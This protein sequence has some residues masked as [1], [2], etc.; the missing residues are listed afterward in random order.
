MMCGLWGCKGKLNISPELL[1]RFVDVRP[2]GYT[3]DADF[4]NTY[5]HPLIRSS[6]LVFSFKPDGVL[7]DTTE[8]IKMI[9]YPL[10]NQ[11]FC[12]NV[13]LYGNG[14]PFHE[15]VQV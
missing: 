12:G 15:F 1:I 7:G 3:V 14:V 10:V 8:T 4:L 13:V 5:V 2:D 11:E 9:D 6:F